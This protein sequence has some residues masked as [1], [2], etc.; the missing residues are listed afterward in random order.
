MVVGPPQH[1]TICIWAIVI[2]V[3][4]SIVDWHF[5]YV[6]S[7]DW[8]IVKVCTICLNVVLTHLA[9]ALLIYTAVRNTGNCRY[10][11][12]TY[13]SCELGQQLK[14]LMF[15]WLLPAPYLD[16]TWTRKRWGTHPS[17]VEVWAGRVI[18][19]CL[20]GIAL[21]T[22][23]LRGCHLKKGVHGS[24]GA[25]PLWSKLSSLRRLPWTQ[26]MSAPMMNLQTPGEGAT[27]RGK[28]CWNGWNGNN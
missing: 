14:M 27:I 23:T 8:Q 15:I 22:A 20:V 6:D 11:G 28:T 9:S 10:K 26:R 3:M 5:P 25:S 13:G 12:A 16:Q 21:H 24:A 18:H 19:C 1:Y 17:Q 4:W 7:W 2:Y